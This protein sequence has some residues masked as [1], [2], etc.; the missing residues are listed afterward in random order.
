MTVV[1]TEPLPSAAVHETGLPPVSLEMVVGPHAELHVTVTSDVCHDEHSAGPGEHDGTGVGGSASAVDPGSAR[2]PRPAMRVMRSARVL[3]SPSAVHP[4]GSGD[5]GGCR[6]RGQ[7]RQARAPRAAATAPSP[8]PARRARR[9]RASVARSPA[10]TQA[11]LEVSRARCGPAGRANGWIEAASS[12]V[13]RPA[14]EA[15]SRVARR[16]Q[17]REEQG[18]TQEEV[19]PRAQAGS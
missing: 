14:S 15:P 7:G 1:V 13:G 18:K 4:C 11:G 2:P 17:V 12:A 10:S 5:A 8:R 3:T 9:G 19:G 6:R 16:R